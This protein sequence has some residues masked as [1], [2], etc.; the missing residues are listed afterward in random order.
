MTAYGDD[1]RIRRRAPDGLF[2]RVEL[3]A[4]ST[5]VT[6]RSSSPRT[7]DLTGDGLPT[8]TWVYDPGRT[9]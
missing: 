2:D 8:V 3:D 4:R 5:S 7:I 9:P 6:T 1:E